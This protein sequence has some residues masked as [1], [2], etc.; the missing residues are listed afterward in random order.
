M[1]PTILFALIL[2]FFSSQ[3]QH[4]EWLPDGI[5]GGSR[6]DTRHIV[7]PT[8]NPNPNPVLGRLIAVSDLGTIFE[9]L[10][11]GA[12]WHILSFQNLIP[13]VPDLH[14]EPTISPDTFYMVGAN[15]LTT[16]NYPAISTDGGY[17]WRPLPGVE[18]PEKWCNFLS[19]DPFHTRRLVMSNNDGIFYSA[20]AG[21]SFTDIDPGFKRKAVGCFWNGNSIYVADRRG[22]LVSDD[23]GATFS[24]A[25]LP[26]QLP[27]P[28]PDSIEFLNLTGAVKGNVTTLYG[29]AKVFGEKQ[30]VRFDRTGTGPF[31]YV[32]QNQE[33]VLSATHI[34][35]SRDFP[36]IVWIAGAINDVLPEVWR[37]DDGGQSWLPKIQRTFNQNVWTGFMGDEGQ[38]TYYWAETV[39]GF[40]A[41][42]YDPNEAIISDYSFQHRTRDGGSS[43][44]ALYVLPEERNPPGQPTPV[45]K[46]YHSN[47]FEN[48]SIWFI[49]LV[50][51]D[52]M[53][54]GMSDYGLVLCVRDGN[55][56]KCVPRRQAIGFNSV[57]CIVK[58]N[59]KVY[60]AASTLHDLGQSTYITDSK[61]LQIDDITPHFGAIRVSND[62]GWTWS[63]LKPFEDP[64]SWIASD[65]SN[66]EVL[67]AS[68][69]H[70]DTGGVF[71]TNDL[72]A[73]ANAHWERLPDP[74]NTAGRPLNIRVLTDGTLIRSDFARLQT[75]GSFDSKAGIYVSSDQ[76]QTWEDRSI[77]AMKKWA[78]D[79]VVH[80]QDENIWVVSVFGH[81]GCKDSIDQCGHTCFDC[82]AWGTYITKNRGQSWTRIGDFYRSESATWDRN[83]P[84]VLMVTTEQEGLWISYDALSENPHFYLVES[85]NCM[86]PVRVFQNPYDD[87][88]WYVASFGNGVQHA[89]LKSNQ[90]ALEFSPKIAADMQN[91]TICANT[92]I[93]FYDRSS[94][95][96][97]GRL[98]KF[99]DGVPA[100]SSALNPEIS[101]ASPGIK[102]VELTIWNNV[103]TMTE[104]LTFEVIS[105]PEAAF[106]TQINGNT[107]SFTDQSTG[108]PASWFWNFNNEATSTAPNPIFTFENTGL[109]NVWLTTSNAC[110]S[111]S[112]FMPILLTSS[113][114]EPS[115]IPDIVF[116]PVPAKDAVW[117]T[118]AA[119]GFQPIRYEI[120][121]MSGKLMRQAAF[122][123]GVGTRQTIHLNGFQPGIYQVKLFSDGHLPPISKLIIKT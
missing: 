5:T 108:S 32:T 90:T 61:I 103:D 67:Y 44:E 36:E 38:F 62:N 80:P 11:N 23:G 20:N 93:Q 118:W 50:S 17:H 58:V 54:V 76:G 52:T 49:S 16:W 72:S 82:H 92:P 71:R 109:V 47:G 78:R 123:P 101:F 3:A 57:Y 77:P 48:T 9:S 13:A 74:V 100:V 113:Q 18:V 8:P 104:V 7:Y 46:F 33:F 42:P 120:S 83:D 4:P 102:T 105:A 121:D 97:S 68:V 95:N 26:A 106:F 43:W 22:L 114:R 110:G 19:P 119:P 115:N 24:R 122:P 35:V 1:K 27:M 85:F 69:V 28:V 51:P 88:D 112:V 75:N 99:P 12:T 2:D 25:S 89:T 87:K 10:D 6:G 40:W 55:R 73:G 37:S 59:G 34:G 41:N 31:T 107:V 96:T 60:A 98:W 64:V 21:N 91:G 15:F 111:D 94:E 116:S 56:W 79:V 63:T 29:L 53:L 84:N 14:M 117:L 30:L 39:L 86:H 81:W 70:P 45:D 66:P 65:P